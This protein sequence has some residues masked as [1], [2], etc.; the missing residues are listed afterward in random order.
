MSGGLLF[1]ALLAAENITGPQMANSDLNSALGVGVSPALEPASV[2]PSGDLANRAANRYIDA[3]RVA[4]FIVGLGT[5]I[6]VFGAIVGVVV[7]LIGLLG[8]SNSSFGR[9]PNE[10]V[11]VVAFV[12]GVGVW[13]IF[14]IAGVIVSAQGQQLKASLDS[15][16]YSSPFL[17]FE[18]KAR[19]M[20]L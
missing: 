12:V 17:D 15:A 3:Y 10:G 11:M 16:V 1:C 18:G 6:K 20:S 9:G 8:A 14:F 2:V 19:A 5:F 7:F 13:F 4:R